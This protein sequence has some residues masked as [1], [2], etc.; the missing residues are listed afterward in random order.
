MNTL[1]FQ[2]AV[3]VARTG[4]ITQAAEELFMAQ[5]NLSKAIRELEDSLG[6]EIFR[7][8]PKGMVPT[9]QGEAFLRY[10]ANVL[11]Q[12]ER[13]EALGRGDGGAQRFCVAMPHAGYIAGAAAQLIGEQSI[14]GEIRVVELG[15]IGPLREVQEGRADLAI[16]RYAQ[17][18]EPY[19]AD[20]IARSS[21]NSQTLWEY[22]SG[23]R[24]MPTIPWQTWPG[25]Y[26]QLAGLPE[27]RF[28]GE[29]PLPPKAGRAPV[30]SFPTG[31]PSPA[32]WPLPKD[33]FGPLPWTGNIWNSIAC[34][35]RLARM[36][37][38]GAG[39]GWMCCYILK[40]SALARSICGLWTCC[41]PPAT[42][43]PFN[44]KGD[45]NSERNIII[46]RKHMDKPG[47]C[48]SSLGS[49]EKYR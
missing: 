20:L 18:Q 33:T 23:L 4:S 43:W 49:K 3:T 31:R 30:S 5:P 36:A 9:A 6:I 28:Y 25:G 19:F 24:C 15:G 41:M 29:E 32:C 27:L 13:M 16:L 1:H 37:A 38:P 42:H 22:D 2:Y 39:G 40:A 44:K 8:T 35:N 12:V 7:R 47:N 48:F 11:E 21:L 46:Y 45:R 17:P 10:A 34:G 14:T 26:A